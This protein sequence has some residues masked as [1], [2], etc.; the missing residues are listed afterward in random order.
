[1]NRQSQCQTILKH[2]R[3][4]GSITSWEGIKRYGITRVGARYWDLK[5][6]GYPIKSEL[7]RQRG[8]KFSRYSL[9]NKN[10]SGVVS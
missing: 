10:A 6:A 1:M 9:A 5:E 3:K 2:I 7:V 8:K 4:F